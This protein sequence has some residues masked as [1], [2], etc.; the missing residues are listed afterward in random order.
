[1]KDRQPPPSFQLLVSV[2]SST[3]PRDL[4]PVLPNDDAQPVWIESD[5]FVGQVVIRIRGFNRAQSGHLPDALPDS[6]WFH[7]PSAG[8]NLNSIQIQGRFKREWAGDQVVFGV[9]F[10]QPLR[11]PPFSSLAFEFVKFFDPGVEGDIE[12]EKPWVFSPL[13]VTMNTVSVSNWSSRVESEEPPQNRVL[14]PWPSTRGQHIVENTTILFNDN[15]QGE[16][17]TTDVDLGPSNPIATNASKRRS[18][19]PKVENRTKLMFKPDQVFG[20]DFFNPI[21]DLAKFKLRVPG[22]SFDITKP[23]NGQPL[24]FVMKSKDSSVVFLAVQFKLVPITGDSYTGPS[25]LS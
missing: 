9:Q 21:L 24:T 8:S 11:L 12:G 19:F 14:P 25:T 13:I 15:K 23:L 17:A 3:D 10:D 1:M 16:V 6:S 4:K 22:V 7:Q 5:E 20:F 18:H 2:G